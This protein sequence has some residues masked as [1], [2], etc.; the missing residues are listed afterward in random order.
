V[1]LHKK[2]GSPI[3]EAAFVKFQT[4]LAPLMNAD[5]DPFLSSFFSKHDPPVTPL[6]IDGGWEEIWVL[7][8]SL[9][10]VDLN[11]SVTV[12]KS[13]KLLC[14]R[15]EA[16]GMLKRILRLLHLLLRHLPTASNILSE[17]RTTLLKVETEIKKQKESLFL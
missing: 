6:W 10:R 1:I 11:L 8:Q 7:T 16:A 5:Q 13:A 9:K 4:I 2:G 12:V 14:H 3:D 17:A 15:M